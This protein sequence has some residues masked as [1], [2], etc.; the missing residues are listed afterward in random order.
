MSRHRHKLSRKTPK[1]LR[2]Q[3]P[4]RFAPPSQQPPPSLQQLRS[5]KDT[6]LSLRLSPSTR[7]KYR[8]SRKLW[9][10]FC[11]LYGL[12]RTPSSSTLE[13]FV[14]YLANRHLRSIPAVLSALASKYSDKVDFQGLR[15]SSKVKELLRAQRV[16]DP[17]R[18]KQAKPL[19]LG[20]LIAAC[21][22]GLEQPSKD[23][24]SAL[25]SAFVLSICFCGLMRLGEAVFPERR[26]YFEIKKYAKRSTFK[27]TDSEISFELPYHKGQNDFT[28]TFVS[29][30]RE[31]VPSSLPLFD[32]A[33]AFIEVRDRLH[34][35]GSGNDLLFASRNGELLSRDYVVNSLKLV[36]DYSGHSLRSGGAT[37]LALIGVREE[38]IQRCGRW[39]SEAF[40]TYIRA[41][42]GV[43]AAL[44]SWSL[45]ER[46]VD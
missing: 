9:Y 39:T 42:P 16:V 35:P 36:G 46:L 26:R 18:V 13:L 19:E 25:L 32:I 3:A 23:K 5:L 28:T 15:S 40:K 41:S 44:R 6:L 17:Y 37:Y 20:D 27:M 31:L 1:S 14:T 30:R 2:F 34:P 33:R 7:D 38:E 12:S 22:L 10:R 8:A 24:Y 45:G 43:L 4:N 11:R 21:E 29:I